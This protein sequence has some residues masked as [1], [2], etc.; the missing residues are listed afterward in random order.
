MGRAAGLSF[1]STGCQPDWRERTAG[2]A[3]PLPAG[4]ILQP[5]SPIQNREQ[6]EGYWWNQRSGLCSGSAM[7]SRH[8]PLS[9]SKCWRSCQ[10]ILSVLSCWWS[11][12]W[13]R[14]TPKRWD[15]GWRGSIPRYVTCGGDPATELAVRDRAVSG[16]LV[17]IQRGHA[18][19]RP[20]HVRQMWQNRERQRAMQMSLPR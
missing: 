12:N 1:P 11:T 20:S 6:R 18:L 19:V 9:C 3:T 5:R 17:F 10:I 2:D 4:E 13:R 14:I 15:I 16:D 8:W 7:V